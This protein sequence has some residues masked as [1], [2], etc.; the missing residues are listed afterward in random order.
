MEL[1]GGLVLRVF[2][3]QKE[4]FDLCP[5]IQGHMSLLHMLLSVAPVCQAG[6]V[7]LARCTYVLQVCKF[8]EII[9]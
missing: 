7:C 6:T 3:A 4:L 9:K 5:V 8:S 1:Q 2:T